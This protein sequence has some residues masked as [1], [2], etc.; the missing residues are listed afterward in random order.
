MPIVFAFGDEVNRYAEAFAAGCLYKPDRCPRCQTVGEWV[1]HGVYWRKPRDGERV[2]RLPIRRWLCK[3]CGHTVSALPDFLLRFRWYIVAVV[4]AVV[5]ERAEAGASWGDLQAEAQ[6]APHVRT[7][8]R[9]WRSLG[10]EAAR[11]LGAVEAMLA[12]Q[13]SSSA[14][15]DPQGE[16]SQARTPIQALLSAAGHLLAWGKSRWAELARYGWKD[17]LRFLGLWGSAQ[18]LGRLI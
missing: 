18:G 16:A 7:M 15:L 8:Q 10:G 4:S 11:W 13:D 6:G 9:W 14:W 12:Q 17:R 5:V 1:G 2:Y 3:A